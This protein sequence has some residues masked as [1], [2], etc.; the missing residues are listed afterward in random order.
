MD[1][2]KL[3]GSYRK[4]SSALLVSLS[5]TGCYTLDPS[6]LPSLRLV[7]AHRGYHEYAAGNTIEALVQGAKRGVPILEF[8]V[9]LSMDGEPFLFHDR[10]ISGA[11]LA[12]GEE[13]DGREFSSLTAKEISTLRFNDQYRSKVPTLSEALE[14]VRPYGSV[15]LPDPK[16]GSIRKLLEVVE[17]HRLSSRVVVQCS[18][19]DELWYA[20]A[21]SPQIGILARIT[22]SH[23]LPLVLWFRP[24]I[25]QP[26]EEMLTPALVAEIKTAGAVVLIKTL[27][28]G[29]DTPEHH[30]ALFQQG[31][32][33]VLSDNLDGRTRGD[34]FKQLK[35][36]LV[37]PREFAA[38]LPRTEKP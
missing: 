28:P 20:N 3:V 36:R 29:T 7:A 22:R 37:A 35:S 16:E 9:R 8:D 4:W 26:D 6:P 31:V 13:L 17:Q 5:V 24:L 15:L 18:S 11:T 1:V 10:R 38:S 12:S 30:D 2:L 25:V 23:H 32:D 14:A 21:N 33:I 19:P 34:G 27:E